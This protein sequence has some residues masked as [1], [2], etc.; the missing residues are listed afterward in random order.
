MAIRWSLLTLVLAVSTPTLVRAG[1]EGRL[2]EGKVYRC[3]DADGLRHYTSKPR[4]GYTDCSL[5]SQYKYREPISPDMGWRIIAG[6][7]TGATYYYEPSL[8]RIGPSAIAWVMY[9][10]TSDQAAQES[11]NA[12]RSAVE[13]WSIDCAQRSFG[14]VQE[15]Y[16]AS[17]F[18]KGQAVGTSRPIGRP[19]L[20]FAVPN[21][22][23]D[24]I[25]T[26]ACVVRKDR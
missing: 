11:V 8:K 24:I 16:Y 17:A 26:K 15:T 5:V 9:S 3:L 18:G 19:S 20:Q 4:D 22:T 25:V 21:S 10:Y 14:V 13:R 23:G 1:E 7:S 12:Y 2:V 6:D